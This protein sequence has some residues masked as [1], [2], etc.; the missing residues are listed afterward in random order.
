MSGECLPSATAGISSGDHSQASGHCCR[1]S[2]LTCRSKHTKVHREES[3]TA[4][5]I[6][7][8]QA[9]VLHTG[10]AV[11]DFTVDSYRWCSSVSPD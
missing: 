5:A 10:G 3:S 4:G 7:T 11:A 8:K 2:L 6:S 1:K 9:S